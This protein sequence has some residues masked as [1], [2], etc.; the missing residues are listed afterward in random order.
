MQSLGYCCGRK[1]IFD[2]PVL[3]CLGKDSCTIQKDDKYYSYLP[4]FEVKTY[5]TTRYVFCEQCFDE[6]PADTVSFD[7]LQSMYV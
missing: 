6:I 2:P 4:D 1:Y 3:R 5:R 7:T